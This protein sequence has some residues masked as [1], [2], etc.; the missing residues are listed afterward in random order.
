MSQPDH[1]RIVADV[2]RHVLA[3][4][5]A[6]RPAVAHAADALTR[7]GRAVDREFWRMYRRAGKPNGPGRAARDRWLRA[8][9]AEWRAAA[10]RDELLCERLAD[11][12]FRLRLAES[13]GDPTEAIAERVAW[14][15]RQA[16]VPKPPRP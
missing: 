7:A 11:E 6:I 14:L 15:R 13:R 9:A 10:L 8:R 16:D 1:Q 12:V 2:E 3:F 5:D 4:A